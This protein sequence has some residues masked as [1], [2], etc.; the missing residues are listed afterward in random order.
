MNAGSG[1]RA[2][3]FREVEDIKRLLTA[4]VLLPFLIVV[5]FFGGELLFAL[6]AVLLS[7]LGLDEYYRMVEPD[8]GAARAVPV[9]LGGVIPLFAAWGG[10]DTVIVHLALAF[11][12]TA[13]V[14]LF[15][16][17]DIRRT[18]PRMA[19]FVSGWVYL[20]LLLSFLVQLRS[21]PGGEWWILI[22]LGAVMFSDSAAFY[23]GTAIGRH[24]LYPSVSP[25]KSVEGALAGVVGSVAGALLLQ[26][27]LIDSIPPL[28]AAGAGF[29]AGIAG[30]VG[31]LFESML[32]RS[33]G[34][35]DSG[36]LFPGH[37]GVLDR[38][39]SILFAAP[40]VYLYAV[41]A[42]GG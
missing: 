34:V 1:K 20:P 7:A 23:V 12:L 22:L 36:S 6:L 16:F 9:L 42:T 25:N 40:I 21:I 27:L 13:A 18:A 26:T 4:V 32:K 2:N 19:L 29:F 14:M 37:G 8:S 5:L 3:N 31:D 30:Q 15:T 24:K 39:D 33:A 11:L 38:L 28:H 35:K 10:F 41:A 17:G